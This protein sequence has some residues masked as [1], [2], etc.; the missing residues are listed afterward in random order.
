VSCLKGDK[1]TAGSE[2]GNGNAYCGRVVASNRG[3]GKSQD[4][5]PENPLARKN[6]MKYRRISREKNRSSFAWDAGY[7]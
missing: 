7:P 1:E 2:T 5:L 3:Y 6:K 4:Q